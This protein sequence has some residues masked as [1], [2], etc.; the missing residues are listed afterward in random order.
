M[1]VPPFLFSLSRAA[2]LAFTR[3]LALKAFHACASTTYLACAP[4][5]GRRPLSSRRIS[6]TASRSGGVPVNTAAGRTALSFYLAMAC[7]RGIGRA[8]SGAPLR[9]RGGMNRDC[10]MWAYTTATWPALAA[11]LAGAL[12]AHPTPHWQSTA[13]RMIPTTSPPGRW[14]SRDRRR[15]SRDIAVVESRMGTFCEQREYNTVIMTIDKTRKGDGITQV[16]ATSLTTS[17]YTLP[18]TPDVSD[19]HAFAALF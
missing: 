12:A 5:L 11:W 18:T 3:L 15:S 2:L 14:T 19:L 8:T 1:N 16:D 6:I 9:T 7:D 10:A 4:L 13:S 17:R